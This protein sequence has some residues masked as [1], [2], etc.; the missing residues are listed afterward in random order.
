MSDSREYR[1]L[2]VTGTIIISAFVLSISGSGTVQQFVTQFPVFSRVPATD[3][4]LGELLVETGIATFVLSLSLLPLYRPRPR[5]ILD[6]V[7]STIN[8]TVFGVMVLA[9]IGYFD[10]TYRLPRLT[11]LIAT[12]FLLTLLPTWL[13]VIRRRPSKSDSRVLVIGDDADRITTV[14]GQTDCQ[15]VGYVAPPNVSEQLSVGR[16]VAERSAVTD[17]GDNPVAVDCLGGL[18]QLAET[19]VEYDIDTAVL[20]FKRSDRQGFFSALSICYEK[21]VTAKV[22][23]DHADKILTSDVDPSLLVTVDLELWDWQDRLT[24]RLFDIVFAVS[25]LII[26][27]PVI[28]VV[29]LAIKIEDGGSVFYKQQRTATFGDTFTV[30]KFRSMVENAEV[31]TG[32]TISDEDADSVDPR[33]TAV[34]RVIR[35][36][37]LDEVPQLWS[38]IT[39]GMSVVGPRPERPELDADILNGVE[40]W[41]KRWFVKPGLTGLAQVNNV[42][43]YE[44]E[45]KL[46][47]DI[48]YVQEQSFGTDVKII[49]RQVFS[50]LTD[51]LNILRDTES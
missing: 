43:G 39:G 27:L 48:K 25:G 35:E 3:P 11:V 50:V 46:H 32:A 20:A 26:L 29:A 41:H 49:V 16:G 15:T 14:M 18:P 34:G 30:Y 24:K 4:A 1:L 37:H 42:T 9:A 31:E 22:H 36:L 7:L 8:R 5:R 45:K 51:F 28:L 19:L 33:V 12:P 17:G 47:Y 13:V 44:P 10:Y 23:R 38:I 2:S 40:D 21:G 6:T